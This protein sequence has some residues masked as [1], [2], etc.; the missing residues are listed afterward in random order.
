M[1]IRY[2]NFVQ[3]VLIFDCISLIYCKK[4]L[5]RPDLSL[6]SR[7]A[8]IVKIHFVISDSLTKCVERIALNF[9][10]EETKTSFKERKVKFCI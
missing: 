1:N 9:G 4:A 8:K 3:N 5:T 10:C 7:F 2:T 6:H